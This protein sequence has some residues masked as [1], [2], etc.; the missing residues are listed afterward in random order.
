MF[1]LF[2]KLPSC[3]IASFIKRFVHLC[4]GFPGY[5]HEKL[6]ASYTG[7]AYLVYCAILLILVAGHHIVY[8]LV[9]PCFQKLR[10]SVFLL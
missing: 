8:R 10:Y 7:T 1:F 6:S 4:V 2:L 5:T 3:S 9:C